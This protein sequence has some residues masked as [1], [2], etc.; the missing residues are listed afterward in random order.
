MANLNILGDTPERREESIPAIEPDRPQDR[1]KQRLPSLDLVR[2]LTVVGMITVNASA[3]LEAAGEMV[4]PV[5][6]HAKWAGFTAADAVFPAFV[7]IVG[8]SIAV[9]SRPGAKPPLMALL[10]R[11]MRLILLGLLLVNMY[12]PLA[13][14]QLWPPRLPGVLQ[15]IGIVYA[16]V[17]F[18]YPRTSLKARSIAAIAILFGYWAL[19]NAPLP[20]GSVVD[21]TLQGRNFVSWFDRFI[22][23]SWLTVKGPD[24]YDPEGLLSTVPAIAQALIGTV[25]GELLRRGLPIGKLSRGF[26]LAGIAGIA[27]GLLWNLDFPI[28]KPIWTS[29]FVLLTAGITLVALALFHYLYDGRTTSPAKGRLLGSF[30]RNAITAYSLHLIL[31]Q[32]VMM[33]WIRAP[34]KALAPIIGSEWAALAPVL[35]FM[36]IIWLPIAIL[37]RR[38]WY[39]KI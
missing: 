5:L 11:A 18:I 8:V 1:R 21:L 19:C 3:A 14:D 38:G 20:D 33:T 32:L 22:F 4:F 39:I 6:L 16:V 30:G 17:A 10:W 28:A 29:S 7:T 23:G 37:D 36:A 9:S 26:A 27:L 12:L 24:G 31:I 15:R 13:P 25:A 35:I 34:I 2:G